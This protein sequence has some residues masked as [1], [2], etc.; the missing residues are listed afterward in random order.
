[1]L[2]K[3]PWPSGQQIPIRALTFLAYGAI[4]AIGGEGKSTAMV[5]G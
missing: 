2:L 3:K 4:G 5:A 1:M